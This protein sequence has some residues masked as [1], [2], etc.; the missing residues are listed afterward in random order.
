MVLTALV[1][2]IGWGIIGKKNDTIRLNSEES[3]VEREGLV[4]RSSRDD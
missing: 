4:R 3:D 1:A 2:S